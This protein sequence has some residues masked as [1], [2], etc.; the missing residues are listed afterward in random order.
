MDNLVR[1]FS[2]VIFLSN[3]LVMPFFKL[4]SYLCFVCMYM[5][6]HLSHLHVEVRGPLMGLILC[7]HCEGFRVQTQ[8]VT[9][10]E[11]YFYPLKN[12]SGPTDCFY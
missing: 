4:H 6:A 8:A 7:P 9:L 10:G 3:S 11:S 2:C 5:S 12:I 1:L